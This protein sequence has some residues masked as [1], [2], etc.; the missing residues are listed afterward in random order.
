[1]TVHGKPAEDPQVPS[2]IADSGP[3]A[4]LTV[5]ESVA[6]AVSGIPDKAFL[7][8]DPAAYAAG[9]RDAMS[10]VAAELAAPLD[11]R[12]GSEPQP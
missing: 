7:H 3:A 1:M 8:D 12:D 10:A 6:S 4:V 2:D 9:F 5:A 11:A